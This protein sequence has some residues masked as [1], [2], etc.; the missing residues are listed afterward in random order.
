METS[1]TASEEGG[2]AGTVYLTYH[3]FSRDVGALRKEAAA[4]SGQTGEASI[5]SSESVVSRLRATIDKGRRTGR[6]LDSLGERQDFQLDLDYLARLLERLHQAD[7]VDSTLDPFDPSAAQAVRLPEQYPF[8][9]L[10]RRSCGPAGASREE[11]QSYLVDAGNAAGL[12]YEEGLVEEL[13]SQAAGDPEGWALLDHCLWHLFTKQKESPGNK[14]R[15]PNGWTSLDCKA[16]LAGNA[17]EAFAACAPADKESLKNFLMEL[18]RRVQLRGVSAQPLPEKRWPSFRAGQVQRAR[19][20]A[21]EQRLARREPIDGTT[22]GFLLIHRSLLE[23]WDDLRTWVEADRLGRRR[24]RV[25]AVGA[26][27]VAASLL[28]VLIYQGISTGWADQKAGSVNAGIDPDS[29]APTDPTMEQLLTSARLAFRIKETPLAYTALFNAVNW[30]VI[31][32]GNPAH[33][34]SFEYQAGRLSNADAGSF[35]PIGPEGEV[36]SIIFSPSFRYVAFIRRLAD[37]TEHLSVYALGVPTPL[38]AMPLQPAPCKEGLRPDTVRVSFEGRFVAFECLGDP[39][40]VVVPLARSDAAL[41][42]PL[43]KHTSKDRF[44]F[45]GG[46]VGPDMVGHDLNLL[47][48]TLSAELRIIT[49]DPEPEIGWRLRIPSL[50]ASIPLDIAFSSRT[51]KAALL[52]YQAVMRLYQEQE[53]WLERRLLWWMESR[54]VL[55][56]NVKLS[57]SEIEKLNHDTGHEKGYWKLIGADFMPSGSCMRLRYE[58]DQADRGKVRLHFATVIRVVD[59]EALKQIARDLSQDNKDG[60]VRVDLMR[61]CT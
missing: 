16:F 56:A 49:L 58:S 39:Q 21:L 25:I 32:H 29:C 9:E 2:P 44:L 12:R 35:S 15:R 22:D 20:Y 3:E 52:D 45:F 8:E 19:G 37:A 11:I 38:R 24:R 27:S 48:V 42:K 50:G 28:L 36:S 41:L 54:P 43:E 26:V 47:T 40:T 51:R 14:L 17:Q 31:C 5:P 6:I 53:G 34:M 4:R 7:A 30:A 55:Y 59:S 13:S 23:R 61:V 10:S 46:V 33:L 60:T 18:G 1:D 57:R